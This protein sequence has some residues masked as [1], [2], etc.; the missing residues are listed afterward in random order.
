MKILLAAIVCAVWVAGPLPLSAAQIAQVGKAAPSF[1][2]TSLDGNRLTSKQ[3]TGHPVFLNFFATWCPPCKLEL[4]NIVKSYPTYKARVTYVGVDQEESP[5]L[6]KPFLKQYAIQYLVGIDEGSVAGAFGV[7]ALPQSV[8]IDRAGI[9][10]AIWRG[11]MP[12]NI[13]ASDM[14]LITH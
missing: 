14:A 2:F 1:A 11:Y 4:P 8:F 7:A 10:R 5:D 13:F 12:P 3:F 6:V 9:V